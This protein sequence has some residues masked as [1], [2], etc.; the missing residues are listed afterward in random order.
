MEKLKVYWAA[1]LF[2]PRERQFNLDVVSELEPQIQVFLPQRDG[3]LLIDMLDAGV[4]Q[5]VAERRIFAQDVEAMRASDLVVAVLDGAV[6]DDGVAFEVGF[7]HALGK[8]CMALQTDSRRALTSGNNPML[9][10]A[11][12]QIFTDPEALISWLTDKASK[13]GTAARLQA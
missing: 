10:Q 3:A 1:P 6:V 8:E 9:G 13:I 4:P 2:N 5:I 7:M 12:M 11:L